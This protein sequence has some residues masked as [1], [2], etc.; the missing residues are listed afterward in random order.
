ME[1][2]NESNQRRFRIMFLGTILFGVWVIAVFGE[3]IRKTLAHETAGLARETLENES[4]KV[5]TQELAMA[6]VQTIL[7]DKDITA[8]AATF[9]KDAASAPETQ[10]A[11]LQLTLHVLQ[12]PDSLKEV[13]ILMKN[14]IDNLVKDE[15]VQLSLSNLLQS[16]LAEPSFREALGSFLK[17]LCSDPELLKSVTELLTKIISNPNVTAASQQLL[18]QS[19]SVVLQDGEIVSKSK[20]FIAEVM[21]DDMLQREGGDALMKSVTYA[22]KPGIRTIV[23]VFIISSSV[24]LAKLMFSP[25]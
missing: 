5:Q 14:M 16:V 2:V 17:D 4:L 11:L 21:D 24:A 22:L 3:K 10:L 1:R 8:H 15:E 12:H 23:G 7:N 9:L 25:F 18:M 6:V 13:T 20:E 19:T